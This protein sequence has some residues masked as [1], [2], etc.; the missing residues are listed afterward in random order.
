MIKQQPSRASPVRGPTMAQET[1]DMRASWERQT[2]R[3]AASARRSDMSY[4][5]VLDWADEDT[6]AEWIEGEVV[7]TS[8]ASLAHQALAGFLGALLGRYVAFR[9]LGVVILAPFQMKLANG[10]EPDLLFLA[11]EHGDRLQLTYL[12]GPADLVVEVM[13]SERAGRDRGDKFFEYA[14][15]GVPEYWLIDPKSRWCEFYHLDGDRYDLAFQGR[16][17]RY[18][19][20]AVPGFWL[21]VPWLW[22]PASR[23]VED[24]LLEVA[25]A[26][27]ADYLLDRLRQR[28]Y[29]S[30]D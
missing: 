7:M 22:L 13:S 5:A 15:G 8:P 18:E 19:S 23:S 30:N 16:Q 1:E 10:R 26:A 29:L 4:E 25:G 3:R 20:S 12:D 27:Y 28:G 9:N 17:G 14:E 2:M 21:D 11:K 24:N 6:L